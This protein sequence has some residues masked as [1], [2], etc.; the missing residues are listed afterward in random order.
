MDGGIVVKADLSRILSAGVQFMPDSSVP[1]SEAGTRHRTADRLRSRRACPSSPS[2]RRCRR[3]PSTERPPARGGTVRG[4]HRPSQPGTQHAQ[5]LSRSPPRR[6]RHPVGAGGLRPGDGTRRRWRPNG[7][8]SSAGWPTRSPATSSPSVSTVAWCRCSPRTD[9]RHVRTR[10][11]LEAD[12]RPA[13][14]DA[15]MRLADLG[16]PGRRPAARTWAPSPGR[17]ASAPRHPAHASRHQAAG[18]DPPSALGGGHPALDH[19][20]GSRAC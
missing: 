17:W 14:S 11:Q 1:T 10:P 9:P 16:V 2:R 13:S 5:P 3:S 7:W 4:R 12:Y 18:P 15:A 20:G 8:S 19:F 6:F